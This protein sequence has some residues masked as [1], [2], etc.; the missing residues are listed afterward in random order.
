MDTSLGKSRSECRKILLK[1]IQVSGN[2]VQKTVLNAVLFVR[3]PLGLYSGPLLLLLPGGLRAASPAE[4]V[5]LPECPSHVRADPPG[6]G[7]DHCAERAAEESAD[8][9]PDWTAHRRTTQN[10]CNK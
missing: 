6:R 2:L 3:F 1:L 8:H 7:P 4:H 10:T 5:V 9:R